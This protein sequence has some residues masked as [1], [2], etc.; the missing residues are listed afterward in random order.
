VRTARLSQ[1]A[2]HNYQSESRANSKILAIL[3]GYRF[4]LIAQGRQKGLVDHVCPATFSYRT[5][6]RKIPLTII[7]LASHHRER[8]CAGSLYR[9]IACL[10]A[11]S[12]FLFG[13]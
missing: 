9:V 12:S 4:I 6:K 11:S 7:T 1:A 13:I 2:V 8:V 10:T 3:I 5:S